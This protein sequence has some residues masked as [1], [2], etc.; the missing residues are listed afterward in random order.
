VGGEHFSVIGGKGSTLRRLERP[1]G[2][3]DDYL[4]LEGDFRLLNNAICPAGRH[5]MTKTNF[6]SAFL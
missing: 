1:A 3:G 5:R 6:I 4:S 2:R